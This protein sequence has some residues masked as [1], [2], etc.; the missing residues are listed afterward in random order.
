MFHFSSRIVVYKLKQWIVLSKWFLKNWP[1]LRNG[2]KV[3]EVQ[4]FSNPHCKY[5]VLPILAVPGVQVVPGEL[6]ESGELEVPE[7][8][9]VSGIL[10]V[11]GVLLVPEV[12]G[13]PGVLVVPGAR[14]TKSCRFYFIL[15]GSVREK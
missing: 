4:L 6:V 3:H 15:K 2:Q 12:L 1:L 11:P 10:G 13:V 9:V 7:V 5:K 14:S 8:L